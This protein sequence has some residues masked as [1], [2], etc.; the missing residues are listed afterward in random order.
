M[1]SQRDLLTQVRSDLSAAGYPLVLTDL[2]LPT[3]RDQRVDVVAFAADSTNALQ[4]SV[5]VEVKDRKTADSQQALDQLALVRD[6]LGTRKHYFVTSEGWHEADSGLRRL[7]HVDGPAEPDRLGGELRDASTVEL[8]LQR[9]LWNESDRNRGEGVPVSA[10]RAVSTMLAR[11]GDPSAGVPGL[12]VPIDDAT[13]WH[14]A[15]GAVR[16]HLLSFKALETS[17]SQ[18]ALARPLAQLLG[19]NLPESVDDPFAGLGGFLW[20]V[21][22]RAVEADSVVRLSGTEVNVEVAELA[23]AVGALCPIPIEFR[24]GDSFRER[25]S[26]PV[27]A[28]LTQPPFGLRL[29]EPF[30]LSS[31]AV[32]RDGELAAID[33]A[34]GRLK[35]G[36]RAVMHISRGWTFRSGDAARYRAYMAGNW[37]VGA[38]IGLPAGAYAG[39]SIPSMI[40]VVDKAAPGPT[41]VANL[42]TNWAEEL[43]EGGVVLTECIEHL[44]GPSTFTSFGGRGE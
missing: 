8:L 19:G 33:V 26:A 36:G 16:T 29:T 21:A 10:V 23:S 37:R 12:G 15:R 3:R 44:D 5:A 35:R 38:L 17:L 34:L 14:A 2:R 9:Y 1:T 22:D 30:S 6:V 4:P 39:A 20:A 41:F 7:L 25:S 24:V 32:T 13:R 42:E 31:G 40:L 28:V 11:L 27:D 18:P 43:G